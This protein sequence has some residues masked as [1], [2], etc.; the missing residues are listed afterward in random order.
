MEE[1]HLGEVVIVKMPKS[2]GID[3]VV[4][5]VTDKTI[6]RDADGSYNHVY[7]VASGEKRFT[8]LDIW[9]RRFV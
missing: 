7:T 1:F 4:A 5:V 9:C 8:A 6:F 3:I 2:V